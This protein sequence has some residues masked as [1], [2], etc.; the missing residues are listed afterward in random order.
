MNM[1]LVVWRSDQKGSSGTLARGGADPDNARRSGPV[2]VTFHPAIGAPGARTTARPVR[3]VAVIEG[4]WRRGL[5]ACGCGRADLAA[6]PRPEG[7]RPSGRGRPPPRS[8]RAA[9]NP[10]WL[11]P[12]P[13]AASR[14]TSMRPRFRVRSRPGPD[15]PARRRRAFKAVEKVVTDSEGASVRSR[16]MLDTLAS[17]EA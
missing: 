13:H 9:R 11:W 1:H 12:D 8:R 2:H 10:A 4:A 14:D 17:L 15:G 5:A 3:V 16:L 7:Y 6:A